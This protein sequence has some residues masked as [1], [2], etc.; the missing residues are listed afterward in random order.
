MPVQLVHPG[1]AWASGR[2]VML[3]TEPASC[4]CPGPAGQRV[5]I[6]DAVKLVN[7]VLLRILFVV[8]KDEN[9]LS[10]L[11]MNAAE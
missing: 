2:A 4:L 9:S 11:T 5:S 6:P 1:V 3:R 10:V 7:S 8:H